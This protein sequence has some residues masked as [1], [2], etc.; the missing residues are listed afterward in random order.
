MLHNIYK[1]G[2]NQYCLK[3]IKH[4]IITVVTDVHKLNKSTKIMGHFV[5][6][7]VHTY[8][9]KTIRQSWD[10]TAMN[11][12]IQAVKK[13]EMAR[14]KKTSATFNVPKTTLR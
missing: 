1:E 6:D 7:M 4:N 5:V 12:A 11:N 10:E 2:T 14:M 13:G 8:K 9:C 3:N